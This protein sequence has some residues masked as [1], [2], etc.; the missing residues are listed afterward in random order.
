MSLY[1][2]LLF[3]LI[4]TTY[5]GVFYLRFY[6][7]TF[8]YL[9]PIEI[10]SKCGV[11]MIITTSL[12]VIFAIIEKIFIKKFEE[13]LK[14]HDTEQILKRYK[15]FDIPLAIAYIIGF[16]IGSCVSSVASTVINGTFN[17]IITILVTL[18]GI[19]VGLIGYT[20]TLYNVKKIKMGN[21]IKVAGIKGVSFDM[22]KTLTV[23]IIACIYVSSMDFI[24]VPIGLLVNPSQISLKTYLFYCILS[25]IF[26]TL[27]CII[28]FT[29]LINSIQKNDKSIKRLLFEETQNLAIATKESA[30]TGQDQSAAI[31]EIVATVEDSDNLNSNANDKINNVSELATKS[32]DDVGSGIVFLNETVDSLMDSISNSN[33][34]TIDGIKDLGVRI[35]TIWD[36]VKVINDFA[37]QA[38]IIAFNSELEANAAGKAGRPFHIVAT[39]IRRLS[40]QIIES[41]HEIKEK[42]QEVQHASDVLITTSE[43]SEK[44]IGDSYKSIELIEERFAGIKESSESTAKSAEDIKSFMQQL[45]TASSQILV[46]MKQIAI[47]VENFSEST[48]NI[49]RT[50]EKLK[51]IASQM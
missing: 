5:I 47:G 31:K 41:T 33:K 40:D 26:N 18:Q 16:F 19:G 12:I 6:H 43:E 9:A 48:E 2:S 38:K 29:M 13:A 46:T 24:I 21:M 51:E 8:I 3:Y 15:T 50:S 11:A 44:L 25:G 4:S 22:N 32:K 27:A 37:D 42:I 10:I 45:S 1:G 17:L 35:G 36:I 49:S 7:C 30:A 23:A 34:N 20:V 28:C 39:E 14:K